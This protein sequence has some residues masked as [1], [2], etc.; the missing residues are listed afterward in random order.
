M[1][2]KQKLKPMDVIIFERQ[3]IP[4]PIWPAKYGKNPCS[5]RGCS[6]LCLLSHQE[7]FYTCACPIGI[8]LLDGSK[9]QCAA[10]VT[11]FL[12]V[13]RGNDIRRISLDTHDYTDVVLNISGIKHVLAVDY[14]V[15]SGFMF[16]TDDEATGIRKGGSFVYI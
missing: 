6:D 2:S 3:D 15:A 4:T 14:H 12:L 5:G 10:S 8:K 11:N 1:G 9:T 7:P 16:W 13:A